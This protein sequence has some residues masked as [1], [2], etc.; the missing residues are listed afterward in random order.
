MQLIPK[1]LPTLAAQK[2]NAMQSATQV[3]SRLL[4]TAIA[5]IGSSAGISLEGNILF[6]KGA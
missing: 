3:S 6:D 2:S 1:K 5:M 4:K